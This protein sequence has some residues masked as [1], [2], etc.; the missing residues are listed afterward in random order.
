VTKDFLL[1]RS[2][3]SLEENEADMFRQNVSKFKILKDC[4]NVCH[5]KIPYMAGKV[6]LLP[7]TPAFAF[8]KTYDNSDHVC[9]QRL[10]EV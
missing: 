9:S 2:Q 4:G 1:Q 10:E 7:K 5:S 8:E 6:E 3:E